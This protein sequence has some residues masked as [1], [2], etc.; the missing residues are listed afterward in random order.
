MK[1]FESDSQTNFYL[2]K[3]DIIEENTSACKQNGF[4]EQTQKQ[5]SKHL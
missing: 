4:E 5:N 3:S 2:I 1:T